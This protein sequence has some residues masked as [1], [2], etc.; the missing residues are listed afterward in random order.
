MP[1]G[2]RLARSSPILLFAL[3]VVV[4]YADP[5][6]LRKNFGGRDLLGY[7]LPIEHSVHDAFSRGRLPVWI[8]EIS[9]GRPLMA[10]P[11]V[12]ALYPV[13]PLLSLVPFPLAMRIFPILHWALAGIGMILLLRSLSLSRAAAWVG[14]V[15]YAFSGV[16]VS[17]VFY[18]N[19]HPGMAL[20][21]WALWVF[22]RPME[23]RAGKAL[24]LSIFF[25]LFAL[26][27]DIFTSALAV[28]SC[29]LW[30]V[31]EVSRPRQKELAGVLLL[32][33]PLTVLLAAPQIVATM[34]WVPTTNRSVLGM[35]LWHALQ[36]S[37]A[38]LRL[39][40]FVVPYPFGPTWEI[41]VSRLWSGKVFQGRAIGY[42]TTLY[43]GA[44][45]AIALVACLRSKALGARFA[46]VFFLFGLAVT[47]LPSFL[48]KR[49]ESLASP[50]PL[51]YPEKFSVALVLALAIFSGIAFEEF[52]HRRETPRWVLAVGG[53]L[54]IAALFASVFPSS[55]SRL[56]I[57]LSGS[58]LFFAERAAEQLPGTLSEAGLFW[59]ASLVA[60]AALPRT[61]QAA[62]AFSLALL[63]L[64]P[65]AA[66]RRIARSFRQD[67]IFGPPIFDHYL[68]RVDPSGAYRTL[69]VSAYQESTAPERARQSTDAGGLAEMRLNWDDYTHALWGRGT[70]FNLD[71]DVGDPSRLQSLRRISEFAATYKDAQNFYGALSLKWAIRS[72]GQVPLAGYR[73]FREHGLQVWDEHESAY[74]DIRLLETWREEPN[75]VAALEAVPRLAPGEVVI[76]SDGR[77]AGLARP[78]KVEVLVKTPENLILETLSPDPA[79]LFV[80]R[81]HWDYRRVLLDGKPVEVVPAQLAFSAVRIPPGRHRIDW[82]ELLPGFGVS[83]WGPLLFAVAGLG[84]LV[85]GSRGTRS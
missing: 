60:I 66:N 52:R 81:G 74:P 75:A 4:V 7:N 41:D 40:E 3:L 16:S 19:Y 58:E 30:L 69:G 64:V 17:E 12:G 67:V 82:K 36:F 20:L 8:P 25:A 79:W 35:E 56:A 29:L 49:W 21:P 51:R 39:L 53:A 14:A 77:R 57:G 55:A 83:R 63:T 46:R 18:S 68:A 28:L 72:R 45:G 38:P 42:Y 76:E 31:L 84:L 10:N 13:R 27:G 26:A 23:S 71:F 11:N 70:V 44:F 50:I 61:G 24:L 22:V 80:L 43:V 73:P 6:F 78:G 32:A 62:L 47:V 9:G 48:P 85:A 34:L 54:A 1:R 33:L 2:S 15:T 65:V 37:V 5:L 59:M